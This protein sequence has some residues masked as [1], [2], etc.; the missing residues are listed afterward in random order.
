MKRAKF[1]RAV[2][3]VALAGALTG[4]LA[5]CGAPQ[6][7]Q[8]YT[9]AAGVNADIGPE[10]STPIKVRNLLVISKAPGQGFLSGA[11]VSPADQVRPDGS[12]TR[13]VPV[14]AD[15]LV[16]VSGSTLAPDNSADGQLAPVPANV[17]LPP[18]QMVVLT[19]QPAIQ[20]TAPG[21][22][23]G[24]LAEL[25]LTFKSGATTTLRVP[26]V[27]GSLPDYRSVTPI[28]ANGSAA[29]ATPR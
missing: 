9:P 18:G 25:T 4:G 2:A 21:L 1:A 22:K 29:P 17:V 12:V 7:L 5:G 13:R 14:P 20:L 19:N 10:G 3:A 28:P 23:P 15:A 6:T 27:D 26:V 16:G 24:L 8:P 11:I